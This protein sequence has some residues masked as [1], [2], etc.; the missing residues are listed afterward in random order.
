MTL[1]TIF[2]RLPQRERERDENKRPRFSFKQVSNFPLSD[3][4]L[5]IINK[6]ALASE[7]VRHATRNYM[8]IDTALRSG[9]NGHL[10]RRH[11][12]KARKKGGR[13]G[14]LNHPPAAGTLKP[15][16]K[17]DKTQFELKTALL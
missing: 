6:H 10:S 12:A 1:R 14:R 4:I 2:V 11:R 17:D 3:L 5:F 8:R 9:K 16:A 15:N 7:R 13:S